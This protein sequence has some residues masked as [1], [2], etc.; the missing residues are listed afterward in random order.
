DDDYRA[1]NDSQGEH[2]Q[3]EAPTRSEPER[4]RNADVLQ[5]R[6][7]AGE[8][9][10]DGRLR[11]RNG[12][13]TCL[14][15]WRRQV[16]RGELDA[17]QHAIRPIAHPGG[18]LGG[19]GGNATLGVAAVLG[20]LLASLIDRVA[21]PERVLVCGPRLLFHLLRFGTHL[22]GSLAETLIGIA[23]FVGK[24]GFDLLPLLV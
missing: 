9:S 7:G 3:E 12:F 18:T 8:G 24:A 10:F 6:F 13:R 22:I 1:G 4:R 16:G 20:A 5:S 17:G 23:L 11:L 15:K 14:R 2:E 21:A 19:R